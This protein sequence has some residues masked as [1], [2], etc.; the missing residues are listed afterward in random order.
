MKIWLIYP[1]GSIPGEGLRPDRPSMIGTALASAGHEVVWWGSNIEHRSKTVRSEE[2]KDIEIA[3]N[4]TLRLVPTFRYDKNIS[5]KRILYEKKYGQLVYI[6]AQEYLTPELI[7]MGEPALFLCKSIL[8][9]VKETGAKLLLDRLDLWPELFH[10]VLPTPFKKMGKL[11]FAPLYYRRRSLFKKADAIIAASENYLKL[12]LENAP[13]LP[14]EYTETVYF[15]IDVA[16]QRRAMK[17][18]FKLPLPLQNVTRTEGEIWAIYASTLGHNYDLKTLLEASKLLTDRKVN[19]KLLIAGTGPLT[20]YV[21]S[22]I[23]HNN[24]RQTVYIGNPDSDTLAHIYSFCDIGLSMYRKSSTVSMPIKAFHYF[25]AGLP[26][27]NSLV[28]DLAKFISTYNTGLNYEAE[29]PDSLASTLQKLASDHSK[30]KVIAKNSYDLA[31]LFDINIQYEKL[32]NLVRKIKLE[33][34]KQT[35]N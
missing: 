7:I 27:V 22:Y 15:G 1:Y 6:R 17:K 28:G 16:E 12:A 8:K 19:V 31:S 34:L 20:D 13:K 14:L 9:L 11:I 4:F 21:V 24:L 23:T 26:I 35:E 10:M 18:S 25:A 3:P 2:W 30:L 32:V 5:I 29:N 33:L